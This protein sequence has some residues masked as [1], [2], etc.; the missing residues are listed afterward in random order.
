[1]KKKLLALISVLITLASLLGCSAVPNSGFAGT[2]WLPVAS[3]S[4]EEG[5]YEKIEYEVSS[6]K[7]KNF[8]PV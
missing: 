5:F 1:M 6:G 8:R 4:Y 2:Y 7:L 3:L